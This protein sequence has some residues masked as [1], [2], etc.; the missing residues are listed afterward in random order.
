[1]SVTTLTVAD[2]IEEE[3]SEMIDE[4]EQSSSNLPKEMQA[5]GRRRKDLVTSLQLLGDYEDMLT[6]PPSVRSI[7][8]QAAA[9]AIMFISGLTVGSGY[10][11]SVS[12]N[13][14]AMSCCK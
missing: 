12:V 10:C 6:P 2:I 8:N 3:E 4:T 5:P 14:L 11:E 7:A 1:M 9:K 13:G